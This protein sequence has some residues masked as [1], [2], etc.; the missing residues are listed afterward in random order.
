LIK[1]IVVSLSTQEHAAGATHLQK[2][3]A[4]QL[5]VMW[6]Q[7]PPPAQHSLDWPARLTPVASS[8]ER[9]EHSP[10]FSHPQSFPFYQVRINLENGG[11]RIVLPPDEPFPIYHTEDRHV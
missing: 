4:G 1:N 3:E 5:T 11:S 7:D 9:V 8:G 10:V 2:Q 6:Q